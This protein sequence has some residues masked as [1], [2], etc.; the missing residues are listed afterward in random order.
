MFIL[1]KTNWVCFQDEAKQINRT[2]FLTS[3]LYF[4]VLF[5]FRSG[6]CITAMGRKYHLEHFICSYCT[7]QLHSGTFKEYQSKPYCHPCFI[8]LF[9]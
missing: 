4:L 3:I 2:A 7:R 9:A 8:K 1:P 5:L 6:R